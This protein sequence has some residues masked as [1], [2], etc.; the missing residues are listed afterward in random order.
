MNKSHSSPTSFDGLQPYACGTREIQDLHGNSVGIIKQR[1]SGNIAHRAF[2]R[3]SW[4]FSLVKT[5][6]F[7]DGGGCP[8]VERTEVQLGL[9]ARGEH[10]YP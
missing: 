9:G 1:T 8:S 4:G 3:A 10:V 7:M 6:K 2:S 5:R